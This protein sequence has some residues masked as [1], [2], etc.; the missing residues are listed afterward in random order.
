[1]K[2]ISKFIRKAPGNITVDAFLK[3]VT[4]AVRKKYKSKRLDFYAQHPEER[5]TASCII[6]SRLQRQLWIIGDCQCLVG[7]TGCNDDEYEYFD[8]PKPYEAII[9]SERAEKARQL[10]ASGETTIESLLDNDV[11]RNS[12]IPRMIESMKRQNIDYAV[13]DGFKIPR[14]KVKVFTFDFE[15]WTIIL[16]SDGYPLL[17]PTLAQSEAALEEQR[18]KDPLNI[19]NNPANPFVATKAFAR[20]NTSFDDRSYI[21]F[22][23]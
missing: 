23:I 1:M 4:E 3:G 19:G 11:A 15:S 17:R 16:A 7:K 2:V 9:A 22:T 8:N 6:Y 14:Q 13:V 5:I 20:G 18:Q 12:V 10:I 21:K